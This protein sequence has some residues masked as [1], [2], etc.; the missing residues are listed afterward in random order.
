M[1]QKRIRFTGNDNHYYMNGSELATVNL[2][3]S[4]GILHTMKEQI[5]FV[6]NIWE[7]MN[8]QGLDSIRN[9]FNTFN[10]KIFV[11]GSST[12]IDYVGGLAVYDSIFF[13]TNE[14]FYTQIKGVGFLNY[15]DSVYSMILP[16]NAAWEK[17]YDERKPYFET[18]ASNADSLRHWNTQYAI[19][20]DL[21][22]RGRIDAPGQRD[23]LISTRENVFYNPAHLFP[24]TPAAP[25]SNGLVY[26]ADELKHKHW[27][28]WQHPLKIEAE[29]TTI[30][31]VE[32]GFITTPAKIMRAYIPDKPEIPSRMCYLVSNGIDSKTES[33]FLLFNVPNTLRAEYKVFAVFAPIRYV[34]P[35]FTSE[36]TKIRY[37]IQQLDRSTTNNSADDQVWNSL[38]GVAKGGL[39]KVPDENNETDSINVKK[40]LLTTLSFPEANY[41]ETVTTIRIKLLSRITAAESRNGYNNRMLLDYI[42]LEPVRAN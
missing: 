13:E 31:S 37:D 30:T 7:Y 22:F 23:S 19:V 9:Y 42:L 27:E 16:T 32:A 39:G 2:L 3:A 11:P 10:T 41:G 20:Q 38:I 12:V 35:N 8:E 15:E 6:K 1:N 26:I 21:V 24:A 17:A 36:R 29:Q 25:A 4:N 28:S 14:M 34:Y 40:M 5:P 18:G 33:T